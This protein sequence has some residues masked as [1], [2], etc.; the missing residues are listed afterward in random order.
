MSQFEESLEKFS[1][2][3]QKKISILVTHILKIKP[4]R[5]LLS[6][7]SEKSENTSIQ[8]NL[9]DHCTRL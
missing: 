6:Q 2:I 3:I 5:R 8:W 9:Y 4:N 7:L 1:Y